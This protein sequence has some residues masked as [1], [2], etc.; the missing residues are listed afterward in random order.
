MSAARNTG[1]GSPDACD[2]PAPVAWPLVAIGSLVLV[3][4]G[5]SACGGGAGSASA[6]PLPAELLPLLVGQLDCAGRPLVMVRQHTF[7]F[8]GD[9]VPD[10]L[11]AVRCDNGA[12]NPPS[13]VFAIAATRSGPQIVG[14]LLPQ[15][16]DEIVSD[17]SGQDADAVVTA[18]AFGPSAPRCCPDLQAVHRYHW[19]GTAF[20]AGARTTAPLPTEG[21]TDAP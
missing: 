12:G 13:A 15:S 14:R 10:A 11:A 19:D 7:D 3:L 2:Y 16:A 5:L 21:P 17:L 8:T 6:A 20:D 9:G 4:A 1:H 18:F